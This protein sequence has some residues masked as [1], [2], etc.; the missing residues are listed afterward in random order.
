MRRALVLGF[1][2]IFAFPLFCE[3]PEELIEQ[4]AKEILTDYSKP[5][6]TAFGTAM[7]TD[8][9]NRRSHGILGLDVGVKLV[10]VI[11]PEEAKT[12]TYEID[13]IIWF[14]GTPFTDTVFTGNTIF[15]DT[16]AVEG[17]PLHI[18]GLGFPG[19]F[20]A[21]PQVNIGLIQGVNASVRW[22][23][24]KFEETS[25]QIF[26]V[27]LNYATVDFLPVPI[28]SL[29]FIIGCGYQHMSFGDIASATTIN[30]AILAKVGISLPMSPVSLSPFAGIGMEKTSI[31]FKYD[32]DE[33][34]EI[35]ETIGGKNKLRGIFGLDVDFLLFDID[36]SYNVG[37]MNSV[38]LSIGVGIR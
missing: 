24:F 13:T 6:V 1:M 37:K 21:V 3:T 25:G 20:F 32:Y 7:G 17:D 8:F 5:I 19:V 35:D 23:P 31:N 38:G 16:S 12:T 11:I 34:I 29:K 28:L 9:I 2:L 4:T 30:G 27:G 36:L 18:K 15:G 26:G 33:N 14:D 22:C 10:W